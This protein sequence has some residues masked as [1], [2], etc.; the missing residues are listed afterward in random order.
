MEKITK[1]K[2]LKEI[3]EWVICAIIAYII[4]LII[5]YFFGTISGVKQASMYPTCK[6]GERVVISRRIISKPELK[7]GEIITFESPIYIAN[8]EISS[9][10]N[11]ADYPEYKGVTKF[12]YKVMGIGKRSYIKRVIATEG[13]KI[14]I[15]EDGKVYVD[16]K[17]LE[18]TYLRDSVK[19]ERIGNYYDLT[20]PKGTIFVMGD[21]RE[22]SADSRVFGCVPVDKVEGN[23]KCRVWPLTRVGKIK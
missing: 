10:D 22:E 12:A 1:K 2:V 8:S 17:L 14:Y 18:E 6:E 4:Y 5:N 9:D 15:S 13:Q 11:I 21:N 23:V 19:T 16:D 3:S 7:Y 20:V